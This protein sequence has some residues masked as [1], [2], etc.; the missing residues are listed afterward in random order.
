MNHPSST[1]AAAAAVGKENNAA[2]AFDYGDDYEGDGCDDHDDNGGS[3]SIV[4]VPE[5]ATVFMRQ[6]LH[7][8]HSSLTCFLCSRMLQ[9]SS[10]LACA[11]TFCWTCIK[12]YSTNN[13]ECPIPGCGIPLSVTG[14]RKGGFLKTNPSVETVLSSFQTICSALDKAPDQWWNH[15]KDDDD[16]GGGG[17]NDGNDQINHQHHQLLGQRSMDEDDDDEHGRNSNNNNI[18]SGSE[19]DDDD[20]DMIILN[21]ENFSRRA[22]TDSQEST[23]DAEG[24]AADNLNPA[25]MQD[26]GVHS[27]SE[28][29]DH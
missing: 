27:E 14:S 9:Q 18:G 25:W 20:D 17:D 5:K 21:T 28:D 29:S 19:E 23:Q 1:N 26:L 3:S 24:I 15:G 6:S 13:S 8:F 22:T 16:N 7:Q 12:S 4:P 2:E 10:T 11:H